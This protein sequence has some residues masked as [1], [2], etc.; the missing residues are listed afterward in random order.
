V[1]R[2]DFVIGSVVL[3]NMSMSIPMPPVKAPKKTVIDAMTITLDFD[4]TAFDAKHKHV[5]DKIAELKAAL[6][7]L[8]GVLG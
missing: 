6:R 4:T 7:D 2:E 1:S 8:A 5:M 3:P